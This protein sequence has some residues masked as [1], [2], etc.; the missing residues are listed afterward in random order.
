MCVSVTYVPDI[1]LKGCVERARV[2]VWARARNHA[3]FQ[4]DMRDISYNECC[5]YSPQDVALENEAAAKQ[6]LVRPSNQL[7]RS[8]LNPACPLSYFQF[9]SQDS[10]ATSLVLK[11]SHPQVRY[12]EGDRDHQPC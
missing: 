6:S 4:N 9:N 2:R 12:E 8:I 1:V 3:T 7:L 11:A 5:L 10:I